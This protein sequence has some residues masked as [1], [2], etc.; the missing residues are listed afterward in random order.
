MTSS[1]LAYAP[2][3]DN[4][5]RINAMDFHPEAEVLFASINDGFAGAAE[6]HVGTVNLSTGVVCVNGPTVDGL[7]AIAFTPVPGP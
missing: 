4:L 6:N 2:P 5:P 7:D 3:V 1:S